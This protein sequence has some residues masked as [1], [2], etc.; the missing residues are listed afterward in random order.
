MAILKKL[1]RVFLLLTVLSAGVVLLS[2][3]NA[4]A[5]SCSV[6]YNLDPPSPAPNTNINV[7]INNIR[8]DNVLCF[9]LYKDDNDLQPCTPEG[10][11]FRC[12]VNSGNSV[13][14]TLKVKYG[15]QELYLNPRVP[16]CQERL[17]CNSTTFTTASLPTPT[18]TPTPARQ[19]LCQSLAIDP[20]NIALAPWQPFNIT[21]TAIP[22]AQVQ[23]FR[24]AFF[25]NDTTG[26]TLIKFDSN[27]L[28]FYVDINS[29]HQGDTSL[30]KTF[31]FTDLNK[32]DLNTGQ[33]PK[34]ITVNGYFIDQNGQ[35]SL[36]NIA[37]SKNFRVVDNPTSPTCTI[38]GLP[39][40]IDRNYGG[41]YTLTAS[42]GDTNVKRLQ[43]W[44][45]LKD[46]P[47]PGDWHNIGGTDNQACSTPS[48]T[49]CTKTFTL[50][51][52]D[53]PADASKLT[54]VCNAYYKDENN[55]LAAS[56]VGA[57]IM[58][59]G[60]PA[61][62]G[63]T[64][65]NPYRSPANGTTWSYC[66]AGSSLQANLTQSC[67]DTGDFTGDRKARPDEDDFNAWE[68]A[69]LSGQS[70]PAGCG[71]GIKA[72]LKLFNIWRSKR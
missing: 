4:Y 52:S 39:S 35:P 62:A 42:T 11:N 20:P 71:A 31:Y 60:S 48:G 23:K 44:Y 43:L 72:D 17:T 51:P 50:A 38:S 70:S 68:D 40:T 5:G 57:D 65:D 9:A 2:V 27:P 24:Y 66:G 45:S 30:T 61:M 3:S 34:R 69:F 32:V 37:C 6:T 36:N 29:P 21:A 8:T 33:K 55:P 14:H 12:S 59:G 67:L 22:T 15:V 49:P 64:V 46:S 18:P 25:N 63:A 16:D 10:A 53:I 47:G 13:N 7:L 1:S 19:N 41:T 56:P 28:G 58:C 54:A 26:N